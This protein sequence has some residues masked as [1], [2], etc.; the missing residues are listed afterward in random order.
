MSKKM[1]HRTL[2]NGL[3]IYFYPDKNK[4]SVFIDLIVRYG[5]F[6]SDFV[7]S[8]KAVHMRNGMAH[9]IEHLL[10]ER[11]QFGNLLQFFGK[12]QMQT[13]AITS[14]YLTDYYV[15]TVEDVDFALEHLIK[16]VSSPIFTPEDIE[17]TKPAIYQEIRM[18]NDEIGRTAHKA[19]IRNLF[20]N[21]SYI[22]RLGTIEDVESFTYEQVKLCYDTFYQ[23]KNELLFIAGN[24]DVEDLFHKI[25]KIYNSLRIQ[26]ISFS[27]SSV[28]E[29]KG[30][31]KEYE[32]I[33]MPTPNDY[34]SMLN[35]K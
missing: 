24:F 4:H 32:E 12:K 25:Q 18:R 3:Q 23:P 13:N 28:K 10:V 5:A 15:D 22:D 7:S 1:V 9:L 26:D 2:D 29:P 30:V 19:K 11:S 14:T 6:Y 34:I 20:Q 21:Y 8:G 17:L 35:F 27:F 16:G 33:V 31:K